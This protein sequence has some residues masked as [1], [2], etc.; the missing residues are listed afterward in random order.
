[1]SKIIFDY[2][3]DDILSKIRLVNKIQ[4]RVDG[5]TSIEPFF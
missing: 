2:H 1:M 3:Y 4:K 5:V